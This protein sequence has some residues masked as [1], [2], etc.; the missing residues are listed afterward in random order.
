MTAYAKDSA[1]CP[2]LT[3]FADDLSFVAKVVG[4]P[5]SM[6]GARMV[7]LPH[8]L[9]ILAGVPVSGYSL[10]G[11]ARVVEGDRATARHEM[12]HLFAWY[13]RLPNDDKHSDSALWYSVE[14][15]P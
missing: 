12:A 10:G 13:N 3:E 5:P 8:G 6:A 7:Y 4:V 15:G 1:R 11:T 14:R 9:I 2:G